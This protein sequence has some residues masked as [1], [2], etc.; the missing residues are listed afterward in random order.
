MESA[1]YNVAI[2]GASDDESRYSNKALHLL[3]ENQHHV[4]PIHPSLKEISGHKVYKDLQSLPEKIH[5]LTMYVR[6]EIST[7]LKEQ[8][9]KLHPVRV[10]FNPGTENRSLAEELEGNGIQTEE[11]C[12]LVLLR[13][14]QF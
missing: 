4:F 10:I 2:L 5:T 13:T 11:A 6:P 14:H 12:T 8:I 7:T 9:I 3:T 1:K